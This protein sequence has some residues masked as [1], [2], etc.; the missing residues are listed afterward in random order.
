VNYAPR[1]ISTQNVILPPDL[2]KL[3]EKLAENAHDHWAL[4]RL[5]DG[6]THGPERND[7]E[8]KHPCLIP[9]DQLPDSEKEYDRKAA[10]ETLKAIMALGCRIETTTAAPRF[11]N[12]DDPPGRHEDYRQDFDMEDTE[13]ELDW[14]PLLRK[15]LEICKRKV[16]KDYKEADE[17]A[18]K[19]QGRHCKLAHVAAVFGTAAVLLAIY[20]LA[21]VKHTEQP[22]HSAAQL[23][24]SDAPTLEV[25]SAFAALIAVVL[26]VIIAIRD[27]WLVARHKAERYRLLKFRFLLDPDIWCD[28]DRFSIKVNQLFEKVEK[29]S[30]MRAREFREWVEELGPIT[31]PQPPKACT[32]DAEALRQL[33]DY[34]RVK[35]LVYQRVYFESR[36]RQSVP[37]AWLTGWLGPLLFLASV[38]FVFL[39]LVFD[40]IVHIENS[41]EI[42]RIFIFLAAAIPAFG[43]G[44]RTFTGAHE[45]ARNKARYHANRAALAHV[46]DH[47]KES[48]DADAKLRD[49][50]FCELIL[51]L[52]HCEWARLMSETE[53]FP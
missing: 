27:R 30:Q 2:K 40:R 37:P 16:L 50:E 12:P 25:I 21:F 8:K 24:L 41:H 15:P 10:M 35:R 36:K 26:W 13:Q 9:Y 28:D 19:H 48:K 6:W 4:Q 23:R 33:V 32:A 18:R 53:I 11:C 22:G 39:H 14:W 7:A 38:L 51:G 45:F 34:Y 5:G 29:V 52:E 47:L 46:D 31:V 43:A 17:E 49:M 42:G 3:T 20:Q 44:I 1:P